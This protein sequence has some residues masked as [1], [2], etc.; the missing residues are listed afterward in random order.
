VAAPTGEGHYAN[1]IR[2]VRSGNHIDLNCDIR[3]GHMSSVLPL[4]AN[5]A[6]RVGDTLQFNGEF[7][8]F[9]DHHEANLMLTRKYR[10]P[11]IVPEVV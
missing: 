1:F 10:H 7:E 4:I 8:K 6:Y 11:Y 9:I 3:E 5:I 2:A